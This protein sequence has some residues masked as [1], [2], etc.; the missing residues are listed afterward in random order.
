MIKNILGIVFIMLGINRYL[1]GIYY[2]GSSI[3]LFQN[4]IARSTHPWASVPVPRPNPCPARSYLW[5]ST[6]TPAFFRFLT[7]LST[8]L[9]LAIPSFAD[10]VMKA[11]E[12]SL[13]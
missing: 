7:R 13:E 9:G 2:C 10:T 8:V 12:K 4:C 1:M 5:Y 3:C 11:G 6:S